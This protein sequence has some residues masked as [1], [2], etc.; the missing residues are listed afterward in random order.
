MMFLSSHGATKEESLHSY[1]TCQLL[2]NVISQ[3]G[4][5]GGLHLAAHPENERWKSSG[6]SKKPARDHIQTYFWIFSRFFDQCLVLG[7]SCDTD[8][9]MKSQPGN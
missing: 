5:T 2:E 9:A 8:I 4:I 6:S 7:L 3:P 1:R